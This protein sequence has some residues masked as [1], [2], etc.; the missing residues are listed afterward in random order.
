MNTET[1][2][3]LPPNLPKCKCFSQDKLLSM[4]MCADGGEIAHYAVA[5]FQYAFNESNFCPEAMP[6]VVESMI[7]GLLAV[8]I[9]RQGPAIE[10][11]TEEMERES[12]RLLTGLEQR[13]RD[14]AVHS[15][16]EARR[17]GITQEKIDAMREAEKGGLQS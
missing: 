17:L 8:V 9:K 14:M 3:K 10:Y 7:V 11:G 13:V 12:L 16:A 4:R 5:A 2:F 1:K 6:F 15:Y